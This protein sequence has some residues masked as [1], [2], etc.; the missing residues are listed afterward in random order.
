MEKSIINLS[1]YNQKKEVGHIF[2]LAV[3][4][5]LIIET[6]LKYTVLKRNY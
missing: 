2:A 1:V 3:V 5:I 4:I 6:F